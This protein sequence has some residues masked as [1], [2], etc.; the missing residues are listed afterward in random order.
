MAGMP[1]S[2]VNGV[3]KS[4]KTARGSRPP[5]EAGNEA[6]LR[7]G[8][9]TRNRPESL[10]ARGLELAARISEQLLGGG[11][12]PEYLLWP[13]FRKQVEWWSKV[14]AQEE[15]LWAWL[16]KM[17]VE[18]RAMPLRAGSTTG[19]SPLSL[20]LAAGR[21]AERARDKL[22]LT[23]ASHAKIRKDL[24]L[25]EKAERDAI[26]G[27]AEQGAAIRGR[28]EDGLKMVPGGLET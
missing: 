4:G 19:E 18:E 15:L 23:P 6:A 28:R 11:E 14:E 25:A 26:E 21:A 9:G 27:L 3:T 16:E 2:R 1:R 17:P 5:F 8:A 24:G 10:S 22:G 12:C 20:W 7:H 13:A